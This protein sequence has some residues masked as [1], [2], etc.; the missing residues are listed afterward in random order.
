MACNYC[1][2]VLNQANG[3]AL[4]GAAGA[5]GGGRAEYGRRNGR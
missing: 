2:N 3:D 1:V 5:I 4:I